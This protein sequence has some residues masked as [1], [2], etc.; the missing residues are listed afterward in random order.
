MD[1]TPTPT[2]LLQSIEE[3]GLFVDDDDID[4][5]RQKSVDALKDRLVENPFDEH[6]RKATQMQ[7]ESASI[8]SGS[9]ENE[10]QV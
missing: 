2:K 6:F 3:I 7:K 9:G 10:K 5:D 4:A 8:Y 1:K